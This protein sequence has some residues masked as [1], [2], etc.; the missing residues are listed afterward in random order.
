M[1]S[2]TIGTCE[3]GEM[4]AGAETN[5]RTNPSFDSLPSVSRSFVSVYLSS[6]WCRSPTVALPST[7]ESTLR[8]SRGS[9][10]VLPV[11]SIRPLAVL[12]RTV[13]LSMRY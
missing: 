10:L 4:L 3:G 9:R 12:V 11:T 1:S 6:F 2:W 5:S 13:L 8:K 7:W